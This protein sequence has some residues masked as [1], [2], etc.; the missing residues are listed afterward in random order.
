MFC[1]LSKDFDRVN[2]QKLGEDINATGVQELE[3]LLIIISLSWN[4][5]GT[6]VSLSEPVLPITV[7]LQRDALHVERVQSNNHVKISSPLRST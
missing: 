1:G 3:Q 7:L 6:R 5:W 4:Y 2:H